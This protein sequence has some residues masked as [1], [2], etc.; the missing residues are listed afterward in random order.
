MAHGQAKLEKLIQRRVAMVLLRDIADPRMGMVTITRVELARDRSACKVY[1]STLEDGG[2][3][4]TQER[5]LEDSRAFVQ[6]E[7][8]AILKTRTVPELRFAFDKSVEGMDRIS[9]LIRE[10]LMEDDEAAR[11]R[12]ELE[13]GDPDGELDGSGEAQPGPPAPFP[14]QEPPAGSR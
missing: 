6:R 13:H 11:A 3:R 1:W 9:R 4:R 8:G 14:E 2:K 5:A 7:V 12:E 10:G